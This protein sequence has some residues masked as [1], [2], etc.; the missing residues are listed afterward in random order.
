MNSQSNIENLYHRPLQSKRSGPFYNAFSY[1]TKI[2]PEAAAVFIVAH[3]QPGELVLDPFAGSGSAG[4]AVRLCDCPPPRM[5]S[6]AKEAG[7]T[8][9]WGPR[10]AVLYE[11]SPLGALLAR[12][13][14]NPPPPS[15]FAQAAH[16]LL[17]DAAKEFAW[18][19]SAYGPDGEP[20][21]IRYAIWSEVLETP[22]CG[23]HVTLWDVAVSLDPAVVEKVFECPKCR[24]QLETAACKRVVSAS[25]DSVTG[26]AI[27]R[28]D[29]RL[30]RIYGESASGKWS[31]P[32]T[33]ADLA[34][35]ERIQKTP[36]DAYVPTEPIYWGDLH[37]SGYHT[38][39]SRFHHLYTERNLRALATLWSGI[40]QQD[41]ALTDALQLL[42]LSYNASHSTLMT[43]VV[44]KK[45]QKDL[46]VTGA[47]SGVMYISGLPVE[48][49]IFEGV[50]RK[51]ETFSQAFALTRESRSR[52]TVINGTSTRLD[53]S[54]NTV[55]YVFTDPP[56][57]DFIPYAEVNQVNE[58]WMGRLTDRKEEA[59]ISPSQRK[60]VNDY[61]ELI[62]T[63]F[64]ELARV[65]SPAG[66]ATVVFHA[67]KPAVWHALGEAF[68]H[69]GF[70]VD[71][72]SVLDKTQVSFKQVVHQGGTRGDAIF[73][74]RANQPDTI[75]SMKRTEPLRHVIDLLEMAAND[76][77]AELDP[78]RLYSRYVSHCLQMSVPVEVTAP[79][80]YSHLS[81]R[82][83]AQAAEIQ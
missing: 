55:D 83:S 53:L 77:L 26:E 54:D 61:A 8:P 31:R 78:R 3:T 64:S 63:V 12:V 43:R 44:P 49:N 38:G 58:A 4:V 23:C 60:G 32:P 1:P 48:K 46:V 74:L 69:S 76:N 34:L 71:R 24:T 16:R 15:D 6:L 37:R 59:I 82:R 14:S 68:R 75:P 18:A 51:I 11:L 65:L 13:M 45:R 73:L 57:G 72:T 25:V 67:S 52:V 66:A 47:Q 9:V 80:F 28:R 22:C 50:R 27:V 20:G 5:I 39:I 42:V 21:H 40:G 29:R 81:E 62:A 70:S 19:Y 30:V 17:S 41:S 7:V 10:R 36:I 35:V 2:D 56:F 79:E 33:A